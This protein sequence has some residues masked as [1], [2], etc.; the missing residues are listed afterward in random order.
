[1]SENL[2]EANLRCCD[3]NCKRC[4]NLIFEKYSNIKLEL[5][6]TKRYIHDNGLEFDLLNQLPRLRKNDQEGD[7]T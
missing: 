7:R 2:C 4:A 5:E 6:T 3:D 1:M